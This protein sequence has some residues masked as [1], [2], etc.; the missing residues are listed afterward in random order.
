M[1][2]KSFEDDLA[3]IKSHLE[4]LEGM[5]ERAVWDSLDALRSGNAETSRHI[6]ERD[7][8]I[9]EKRYF[10]QEK[11]LILI[12]RRQ[13]TARDLRLAASI[14]NIADELER[15][16]DYAKGIA[17][18]TLRSRNI[19]APGIPVELNQMALKATS[20]LKRALTAFLA[21]DSQ[22]AAQISKEDDEIDQLYQKTY[23]EL[24]QI[25]ISNSRNIEGVDYLFWVAHNLERLG[26]RVTNI[27]ER[28][29]FLVTGDYLELQ[30]QV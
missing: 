27:C 15:M 6:L 25:V 18:I 21:E 24:A 2:P 26:D 28:T 14:F 19:V 17:V 29:F 12:V 10:I 13:P 22:Q 30:Q 20:M 8:E 23:E 5:V 3:E 11:V 4:Q 16:G 9:N 1:L 7:Q